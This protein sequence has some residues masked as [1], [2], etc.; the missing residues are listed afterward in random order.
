MDEV[1]LAIT[2]MFKGV[3]LEDERGPRVLSRLLDTFPEGDPDRPQ[4]FQMALSRR[5]VEDLEQRI[6]EWATN[7]P[8]TEDQMGIVKHGEGSVIPESEQQKTAA[9]RG[10]M[11]AEAAEELAR[12]NE[13]ADEL[14]RD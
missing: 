4:T 9:Q 8:E 11:S 5:S 13:R 6:S 12:E 7:G 2:F 10:R 14:D 1:N 3:G